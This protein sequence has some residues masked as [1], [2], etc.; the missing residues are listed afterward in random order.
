MGRLI[1]GGVFDL[2]DLLDVPYEEARHPENTSLAA[3]L[4]TLG[5]GG[6]CELLEL[7]GLD[8]LGFVF[9][10]MRA[11]EQW[12][13]MEFS[14]ICQWH[15]TLSPLAPIGKRVEFGDIF[16][17]LPEG[18]E[19]D[20]EGL[21]KLHMGVFVGRVEGCPSPH[22]ILHNP[23]GGPSVTWALHNFFTKQAG[24]YLARVKRPRMRKEDAQPLPI[25]IP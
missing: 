1:V 20:E 23:K 16:F 4:A 7:G 9:P 17:F 13:D 10:A 5:D 24:Y 21:L 2:S 18:V 6:N 11:R 15:E 25:W 3:F 8:R 14:E 12:Y 22:G 19:S